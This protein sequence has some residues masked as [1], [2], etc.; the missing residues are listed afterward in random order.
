MSLGDRRFLGGVSGAREW[1]GSPTEYEL[2][3]T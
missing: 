1:G 2:L 3:A